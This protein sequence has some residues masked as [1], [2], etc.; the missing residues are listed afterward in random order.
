MSLQEVVAA[1]DALDR[2]LAALDKLPKRASATVTADALMRVGDAAHRAGRAW[3][4]V[5]AVQRRRAHEAER[6]TRKP[7]KRAA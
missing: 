7:R 1:R 4:A 5:V 6:S 2:A 3:E